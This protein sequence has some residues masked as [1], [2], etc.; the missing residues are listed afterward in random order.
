MCNLCKLFAS[1]SAQRIL[2]HHS[3][4]KVMCTKECTE[5]Q[6]HE[7]A[8]IHLYRVLFLVSSIAHAM[9]SK[10]LNTLTLGRVAEASPFTEVFA[11]V[12]S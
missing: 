7:K 8:F 1:M 6:G 9:W 4:C 3:G 5:Q 12:P 10:Q 2:D 11:K